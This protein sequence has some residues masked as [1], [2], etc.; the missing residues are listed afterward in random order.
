MSI[1]GI[2][3]AA[4]A[5]TRLGQPKALLRDRSGVPLL[6]RATTMLLDGGCDTVTV[7]LGAAADQATV[8]VPDRPEVSTV[9]AEDWQD[10]LSASVRAGLSVVG[11]GAVAVL[12]HLVD[13]P[14]VP[15]A[16]AERVLV[17]ASRSSLVRA[18]YGGR[19][20]HPVLIGADH[21]SGVRSDLGAD[22]G[23][24]GYL[25]R[26]GAELIEC[27]DLAHGRDVDLPTD[28]DDI[29]GHDQIA[30]H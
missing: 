20:G 30:R 11:E 9:I 27:G 16:A 7:V 18:A 26:H 17:G 10:G 24:G 21:L 4:G 29:G 6:H 15:A 19:P 1:V 22:A 12:I 28:L 2:L 5:G 14:D 3:L 23:A 8:L 13:L 25:A